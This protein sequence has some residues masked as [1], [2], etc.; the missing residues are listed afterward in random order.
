MRIIWLQRLPDNL[1]MRVIR[2]ARRL[3][4]SHQP[5]SIRIREFALAYIDIIRQLHCSRHKLDSIL[6]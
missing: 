1:Q 4:S 2:S 3:R 6:N 5:L